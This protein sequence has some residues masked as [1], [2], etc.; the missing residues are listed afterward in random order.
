MSDRESSLGIQE[1]QRGAIN[2]LAA[3]E[4]KIIRRVILDKTG[5]D[6][7]ANPELV[8]SVGSTKLYPNRRELYL[9]GKLA[10]T[11][12]NATTKIDDATI[13][14]G[15]KVSTQFTYRIEP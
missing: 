8:V 1:Q 14:C 7:N 4:N 13:D 6:F 3:K 5:V 2:N 15:A 9:H 12:Y 11:I 10:L